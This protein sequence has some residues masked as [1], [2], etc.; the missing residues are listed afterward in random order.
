P[1]LPIRR[2]LVLRPT[3]WNQTPANDASRQPLHDALPILALLRQR[4][5]RALECLRR[6]A[7]REL[8]APRHRA[9]GLSPR[10]AHA[11]AHLAEPPSPRAQPQA[12]E[13]DPREGRH[14]QAA[15]RPHAAG[16]RR[17]SGTSVDGGAD[18]VRDVVCRT[19]TRGG[20]PTMA[21]DA[22]GANAEGEMTAWS[23]N[24]EWPRRT[25]VLAALAL[26]LVALWAVWNRDAAM[27][28]KA[29][30]SPLGSSSAMAPLPA[31]RAPPTPFATVP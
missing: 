24:R 5:W 4:R 8:R 20:A 2:V 30:M 21:A 31:I 27:A 18:A 22:V 14:S 26:A 10:R 17:T 3:L 15:P 12:L 25:A 11:P 28:W 19:V 9:V 13:S 7:H 23:T 6:L 29:G 16:A 1:A